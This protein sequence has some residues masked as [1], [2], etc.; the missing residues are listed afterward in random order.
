MASRIQLSEMT[1]GRRDERNEEGPNVG[2]DD[3]DEG[4]DPQYR[5]EGHGSEEQL[6]TLG[7]ATEEETGGPAEVHLHEPADL[8]ADEGEEGGDDYQAGC[9][10]TAVP[11]AGSKHSTRPPP[12]TRPA[13]S[14]ATDAGVRTGLLILIGLLLFVLDL[15]GVIAVFGAW[16]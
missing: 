7:H 9:R 2:H 6:L 16:A 15:L 5:S 14:N 3:A 12:L 13:G 10:A 8:P 4:Y 1:S 11:L